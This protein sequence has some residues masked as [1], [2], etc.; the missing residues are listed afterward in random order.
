MRAYWFFL[1]LVL[2][3][4][5]N[6]FWVGREQLRRGFP[7]P[8][9]WMEQG[10]QQTEEWILGVNGIACVGFAV[11]LSWALPRLARRRPLV[12]EPIPMERQPIPISTLLGAATRAILGPWI[13]LLLG[14][15]WGWSIAGG[16]FNL[17]SI[18]GVVDGSAREALWGGLIGILPGTPLGFLGAWWLL[19][20]KSGNI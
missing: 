11:V 12:V 20:R 15:V 1:F 3:G 9:A 8:F 10:R 17:V 7:L 19:L 6:Y 4:V 14:A 2:F 13:G 5:A 18:L 16:L